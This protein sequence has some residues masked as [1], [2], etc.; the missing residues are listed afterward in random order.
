MISDL[1]SEAQ[2]S[3]LEILDFGSSLPKSEINSKDRFARTKSTS[4]MSLKDFHVH[5]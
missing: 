2:Y 5:Q 1:R 4:P 3:P